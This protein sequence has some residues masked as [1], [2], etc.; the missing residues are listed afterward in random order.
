MNARRTSAWVATVVAGVL[1][2]ALPGRVGERFSPPAQAAAPGP[3]A[4]STR[5]DQVDLALTVY[6]SGIALVRDVRSLVVGAGVSDLRFVDVAAT[7]DPATVHIRSASEPSRLAVLEQNYEYDLLEPDKLLRKYVGR[8]VTLVRAGAENGTRTQ[9]E[10]KATLVSYNNGPIWKVGAE[11]VTGFPS[12][13][14]RFPNLPDN[15][16]S[17]PT[18]VWMLRNDGAT[19]HRLEASYLASGITWNADYV[20]TVDRGDRAADLDGWVTLRNTSGTG[21]P[22]AR[23]QLVA[24]DLHR[25]RPAA[26]EAPIAAESLRMA[27]QAADMKEEAFAEYHLY[28]LGR[29][30]SIENQQTK[31]VALLDGTGIPVKKRYVVHGQAFFYRGRRPGLPLKD[32]VQVFYSFRNDK[33][34]GLGLPMPAGTV[35]VYQSAADGGVHFVGEDRID[36]TPA[37][38]SLDLK[39][40]TAFD[41]VCERKQTDFQKIGDSSYEAEFEIA[42]RNQKATAVTV[43][44]HEP[45]GGTWRM[46][47]SSHA[48]QKTG[49]WAARFDVP[50]AAQGSATLTYRVRVDF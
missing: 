1:V 33:A 34:S 28:T 39:I 29:R 45:I 49:A 43:E 10:V 21:F 15:L 14:I 22:S 32:Q 2:W 48:A 40:G 27:A 12:D 35:R 50:V 25:V 31:Q 5:G 41:V 46:L 36:H 42:L 8:E 18:L 47:R 11:Y 3:P 37:D 7:I 19:A 9:E 26:P 23:L 17:K 16:Y 24:G 44:V 30:T 20:L 4:A 13:H 38:E 6:N